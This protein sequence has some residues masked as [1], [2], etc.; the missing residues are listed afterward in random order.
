MQSVHFV[1]SLEYIVYFLLLL[2][3]A[4]QTPIRLLIRGVM[5]I[6]LWFLQIVAF[7]LGIVGGRVSWDRY[8]AGLAGLAKFLIEKA[9]IHIHSAV[10]T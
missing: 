9:V 6:F 7:L 3:T 5:L 1:Y 2:Q 8:R 4:L 10:T